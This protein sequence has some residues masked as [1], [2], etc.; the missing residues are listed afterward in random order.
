MEFWP[1]LDG[2]ANHA[3][4]GQLPDRYSTGQALTV[5]LPNLG[6]L[7]KACFGSRV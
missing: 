2:W 6:N 7:R 5:D 4:L 1:R 3:I